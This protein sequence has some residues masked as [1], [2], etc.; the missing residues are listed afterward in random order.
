MRALWRDP[1]R[2]SRA[3]LLGALVLFA[4]LP[5]TLG[6]A[7]APVPLAW[8]FQGGGN[9]TDLGGFG[10]LGAAFEATVW[11]ASGIAAGPLVVSASGGGGYAWS[12]SQVAPGSLTNLTLEAWLPWD[13]AVRALEVFDISNGTPRV[14]Y[15]GH[16]IA[17]PFNATETLS[18]T[19]PAADV[20]LPRGRPLNLTFAFSNRGNVSVGHTGYNLTPSSPN[21]SVAD[22]DAPSSFASELP[23]ASFGFNATLRAPASA[24][25]E[26]A[27]VLVRIDSASSSAFSFAVPVRILPNRNVA[28]E[29]L[30]TLP[31]PPQENR[32]AVLRVT[33]H[34]A[35]LDLAPSTDV[36]VLAYNSTQPNLYLNTTR[37]DLPPGA[38][39]T[40]DFGWVPLWSSEPVSVVAL[41]TAA[42]DFD[43]ADDAR[44]A[45]FYVSPTNLPPVVTFASPPQGARVAGNITVAGTLQDP[46]GGA[47][48]TAFSLDGGA[49]FATQNGTSFAFVLDLAPLA[50]GPHV[51]RALSRDDRGNVGVGTL[52]LTVLN[53]G[54]NSP[55]SL[56]VEAPQDGDVLGAAAIAFGTASDERGELTAVL[57]SIDGALEA[58]ANGT[59][60][61]TFAFNGT[62]AGA[63]P[64][65]LS[66][67]AFDGVEYSAAL[68]FHVVVN[69]TPP[70]RID[71]ANLTLLPA[72]ALPGQVLDLEGS[73]VFDTG[74]LAGGADVTAQVRQFPNPVSGT[75]DGRGRFSLAVPAPPAVG[76]YTVDLGARLAAVQGNASLPLI[77]SASTLPDMQVLPS[78][79]SISPD[80][81][82]PATAI[83]HTID[84]LNNGS[85]ASSATV[86]VWDGPRSASTLIYEET[87]T[88]IQAARQAIFSHAYAPG[89][90]T[91][92]IAVED[93][94]PTEARPAD[95]TLTVVIP[96]AEA[97]DFL[98]ESITPS[99]TPV[100]EGSNITFLVSVSNLAATAGVVTVE[101]WDGEPLALNATLIHQESLGIAG[102]G[103]ERV[104]GNWRPTAGTHHIFA[105]AVL[106]VPSEFDLT[107]NE[108]NLTVEVQA[109]PV[110]PA[111]VFLPGPGAAAAFAALAPGVWRKGR[112]KPPRPRKTTLAVA[113]LAGCALAAALLPAPGQASLEESSRVPGPLSGVC[114]TC[115]VNADRG[116]PLNPFGADY[117]AERNATG[118]AV[119]WT[120]LE[121]KDSDGD[122]FAN[123]EELNGSYLP[124]DPGS[125]PRTGVTYAGLGAEGIASLLT[126]LAALVVVSLAGVWLGYSMWAR[127]NARRARKE[128][129]VS[130]GPDADGPPAPKP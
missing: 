36:R 49:A 50:D 33:L 70:S 117:W 76:A 22:L 46:E 34:N 111:P 110:P 121:A 85:V 100:V 108:A 96:V 126:G 7:F 19:L 113:L 9:L 55:P 21:L 72:N 90:H 86:R 67:R 83:R 38:T 114:L 8:D 80:P 104:L 73:A 78:G 107:N 118:G 93:V 23:G 77:V 116:G 40:L 97:P 122:G 11:G 119:N 81:P 61:W 66:V 75:A 84:V 4:A 35:G 123:G 51:V 105:K 17:L 18:R 120:R 98:V 30:T 60:A 69:L 15:T 37:V 16:D 95:N 26:N 10:V 14:D 127:R 42:F 88:N 102:G 87:F 47:L 63:G 3:A 24:G 41:A 1:G 128:A 20:L 65:T 89:N 101:I 115:H 124:G 109:V 68:L 56:V 13:L 12:V 64:H 43:S 91:L 44:S 31:Y 48:S 106:S 82:P 54:P 129:A 29:G 74:V 27:S 94:S 6:A 130:V 57:V 25:L 45:L 5:P 71:L 59:A 32:S 52:N 53:R 28:V 62:A 99:S 103:R 58:S 112:A 125:N 79:F 2:A 92:T 39:G